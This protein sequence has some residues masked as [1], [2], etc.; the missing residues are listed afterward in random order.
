MMDNAI[1]NNGILYTLYVYSGIVPIPILIYKCFTVINT[2]VAKKP[3]F[4]VEF[5][6]KNCTIDR[7]PIWVMVKPYPSVWEISVCKRSLTTF[8]WGGSIFF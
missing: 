4:P 8:M 1:H 3:L 2:S 5:S 6:D 7:W